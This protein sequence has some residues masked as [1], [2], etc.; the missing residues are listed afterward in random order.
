M[1]YKIINKDEFFIREDKKTTIV[2]IRKTAEQFLLNISGYFIFRTII[3]NTNTDTV[4]EKVQD[5]FVNVDSQILKKDIDNIIRMMKIYNII[6]IDTE[7][8]KNDLSEKI[9]AVDEDEYTNINEFIEK[10]RKNKFLISGGKGYYVPQNIRSHVMNNQEYYYSITCDAEYK[11]VAVVLPN[12]RNT[13]VINLT[14]L[15]FDRCTDEKVMIEYGKQLLEHVKRNMINQ[16]NKIRVSFY[17]GSE[18]ESPQFLEL[19]KKIGFEY[20]AVLEREYEEQN[21]YMY[22]MNC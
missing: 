7:E 17:A 16:V 13:S 10:N 1:N 6:D 11:A 21:L 19:L 12:V 9:S 5:K 2:M 4:L 15:I 8:K 18:C 14:T 22:C 20:E 3:D